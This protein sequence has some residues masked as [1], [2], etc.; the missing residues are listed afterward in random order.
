VY[1]SSEK[2]NDSNIKILK[3]KLDIFPGIGRK[4]RGIVRRRG[5]Y[6]WMTFR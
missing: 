5:S 1:R 2:F 3:L 4:W 6:F